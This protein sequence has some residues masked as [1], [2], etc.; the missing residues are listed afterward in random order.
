MYRL[1]SPGKCG[2]IS[3]ILKAS[4]QLVAALGFDFVVLEN[5]EVVGIVVGAGRQFQIFHPSRPI[6]VKA[7]N[8]PPAV[9]SLF[10][11]LQPEIQNG[12]LQVIQARVEPPT[13][14]FAVG[15]AAMVA[16]LEHAFVDASLLVTTA[17]PSPRQPNTLAGKKLIAT[18]APKVP[19]ARP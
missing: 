7:G 14:D 10:V 4:L 18:A 6:A 3:R 8:V 5:I 1:P 16:Q 17:P 19:A 2:A 12:G 15:A 9:D 11:L 13:H